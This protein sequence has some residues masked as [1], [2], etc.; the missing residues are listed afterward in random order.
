MRIGLEILDGMVPVARFVVPDDVADKPF[1]VGRVG[2]VILPFPGVLPIH[3]AL[4]FQGGR[5][6]AAS[7]RD[8]R[9]AV[10]AGAPLPTDEWEEIPITSLIRIGRYALRPFLEEPHPPLARIPTAIPELDRTCTSLAK[11]SER[12]S[13]AAAFAA[14][15]A[16]D[17][18]RAPLAVKLVAAMMPAVAILVC[19]GGR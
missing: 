6:F 12:A 14:R 15:F 2:Q 4:H 1:C 9:P 17:W 16:A 10:V 18:E 11:R 8:D 7:A 5:L 3:A 13:R 19:L